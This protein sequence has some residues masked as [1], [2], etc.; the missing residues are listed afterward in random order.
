MCVLCDPAVTV[1]RERRG[2]RPV[3]PFI[4]H[5]SNFVHWSSPIPSPIA[6]LRFGSSIKVRVFS[7]LKCFV[8]FNI[9]KTWDSF[10]ILFSSLPKLMQTDKLTSAS[11]CSI[12]YT[13]TVDV[14]NVSRILASWILCCFCTEP[15][16]LLYEGGTLDTSLQRG[17][18]C[19]F[20]IR[21]KGYTFLI[22]WSDSYI[23]L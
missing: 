14:L 2:Q 8:P 15:D 4:H 1:N 6:Y 10:T 16:E 23:S 19:Q 7:L 9:H 11:C 22:Q 12:S 3:E 20:H 5:C 17:T 18:H 13:S 21:N